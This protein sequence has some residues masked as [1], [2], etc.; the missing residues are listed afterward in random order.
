MT[1]GIR[2]PVS[3]VDS[4]SSNV[5]SRRAGIEISC[6]RA[7]ICT[8][9]IPSRHPMRSKQPSTTRVRNSANADTQL[10]IDRPYGRCVGSWATESA[11]RFL[12][13]SPARTLGSNMTTDGLDSPAFF[14]KAALFLIRRAAPAAGV[15][16]ADC[17][18]FSTEPSEHQIPMWHYRPKTLL[19]LPADLEPR[20]ASAPASNMLVK[21]IQVT[22]NLL[23]SERA[24]RGLKLQGRCLTVTSTNT[25]RN[26]S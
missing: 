3:Q 25:D 14:S 1:G 22:A 21:Q 18:S 13:R 17:A 2:V 7:P 10:H 11:R 6:M 20:R 19:V 23:Q 9:T 12:A 26:L 24:L 16:M 8:P 5:L 15:Q 4:L